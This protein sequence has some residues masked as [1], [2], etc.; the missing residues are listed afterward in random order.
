MDLRLVAV[1]LSIIC[2]VPGWA[3]CPSKAEIDQSYTL[4]STSC[5]SQLVGSELTPADILGAEHCHAGQ[6]TEAAGPSDQSAL[7]AGLPNHLRPHA[8][9]GGV[10]DGGLSS[11]TAP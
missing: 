6:Q 5:W 4:V 1:L 8:S 3:A 9:F 2:V 11:Y 7:L 10:W